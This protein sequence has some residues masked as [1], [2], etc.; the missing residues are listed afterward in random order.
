MSITPRVVDVSH[1]NEVHDLHATANA[2]IWGVIHKATQGSRYRDPDYNRR[3][4]MAR[5]AGL[6]WGAYHFNDGSD[7]R[8]QVDNF[9]SFASPDDDTLMVLDFEDNPKSNMTIQQAVQ[10]LRLME[11]RGY[12][13]AVYSGNR[14]KE[15][16]GKLSQSDRAYLTSHYLWLCQYGP[17]AVLPVGW[18]EYL[19]WQYTGDGVGPQPHNVPGITAGNGG[20][21]LNVFNGTREELDAKWPSRIAG[22]VDNTDLSASRRST[23]S[24]AAEADD[25]PSSHASRAADD[26]DAVGAPPVTRSRTDDAAGGLNVQPQRA[27]Y[28]LDVEVAQRKLQAMGY[29][30]G[31]IDGL[32]GG[33]TA[34]AIAAFYNDRGI[35]A[36]PAADQTLTNAID[37][38]LEDG[39]KRPIAPERA[40]AKPEDIAPKNEAVKLNLLQRLWAQIAAGAAGLGLVGSGPG[41]TFQTVRD[42]LSG[43]QDVF[44]SV[45]GWAWF[46]LALVVAGAVWYATDRAAKATTTDYNTG[47]L[48]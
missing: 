32:W 48:K 37:D 18:N 7:V 33:H 5:E 29:F 16:I 19:L 15:H 45:P 39:F 9:I 26:Q 11:Q 10:F 43:V 41:S 47:R 30:V 34:G 22:I 38:A 28:S 36:V 8:S 23:H 35:K 6:N 14:V 3:R 20:T 44:A 25:A 24:D 46:A 31:G 27:R 1:H 40:D 4:A 12:K 2:G 21:D 13:C 17:R 42:K